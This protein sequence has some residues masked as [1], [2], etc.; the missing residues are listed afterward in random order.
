MALPGDL[1]RSFSG[2]CYSLFHPLV[3]EATRLVFGGMD[4]TT[5]LPVSARAFQ[6]RTVNGVAKQFWTILVP[7]P[8]MCLPI[9]TWLSLECPEV[10]MG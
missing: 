1:R 7:S 8:R 3:H 2:C 10:P 4:C 9:R 6:H 5:I